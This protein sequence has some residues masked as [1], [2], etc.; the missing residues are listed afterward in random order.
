MSNLVQLKPIEKDLKAKEKELYE[1]VFEEYSWLKDSDNILN[2]YNDF[3]VKVSVSFIKMNEILTNQKGEHSETL[4]MLKH[5]FIE[6]SYAVKKATEAKAQNE[7]DKEPGTIYEK[8][9]SADRIL[10]YANCF[11]DKLC[12]PLLQETKTFTYKKTK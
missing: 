9:N 4:K 12:Y 6:N 10:F 3:S 2:V 8:D 7:T 5:S 11:Y 1:C